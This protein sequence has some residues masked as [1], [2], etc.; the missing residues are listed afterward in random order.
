MISGNSSLPEVL[1]HEETNKYIGMLKS[2]DDKI[3]KSKLIEHNL[4][5]VAYIADR[6]KNT[7]IDKKD[8]ISIGTI[9]LIKAVNTFDKEKNFKLATYATRCIENEIL[10]AI[11]HQKNKNEVSLD[12]PISRDK[13][14][15]ELSFSD[16]ISSN[17][18]IIGDYE[19]KVFR[20]YFYELTRMSK[21]LND[22]E[23]KIVDLRFGLHNGIPMTQLQIANMM[24]IS[25][26]YISRIEKKALKL[27]RKGIINREKIESKSDDKKLVNVLPIKMTYTGLTSQGMKSAIADPFKDSEFEKVTEYIKE[28]SNAHGISFYQEI[29]ME[30]LSN[31]VGKLKI[32]SKEETLLKMAEE[33]KQ[34]AIAARLKKSEEKL[35]LKKA[36]EEAQLKMAEEKM[37]SA[38]AAKLKIEEEK[39]RISEEKRRISY[40][41]IKIAIEKRRIKKW[42]VKICEEMRIVKKQELCIKKE[43]EAQQK[44][45][46]REEKRI[47]KEQELCIKKEAEAQQ[48]QQAREEKRKVKEQELSI[49]KEEAAQQKQQSIEEKS[50]IKKEKISKKENKIF[51]YT[52]DKAQD[53]Y[54][55]LMSLCFKDRVEYLAKFVLEQRMSIDDIKKH[56]NITEKEV[57]NYLV[58]QLRKID[59]VTF[60]KV[61]KVWL[62][63]SIINS[64]I[65]TVTS[66]SEKIY[67]NTEVNIEL[68]PIKLSH[69]TDETNSINNIESEIQNEI[70]INDRDK[71]MEILNMMK[72]QIEKAVYC[73]RNGYFDGYC[74]S[75]E[76]IENSSIL[77]G[78]DFQYIIENSYLYIEKNIA[79]QAIFIEDSSNILVKE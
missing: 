49:K 48:K 2:S 6:F 74:Y 57:R 41:K 18:D 77:S 26:S 11:R 73:L 13:D 15:N 75:K 23:I 5:L 47:V 44:Q 35:Q 60:E 59:L 34:T 66:D 20:E 30:N 79:D 4:R 25:Q 62:N 21:T 14:G 63:L 7:G 36:K 33:K 17:C 54:N 32:M 1:S 69:A 29:G 45:Q 50:K 78:L 58:K 71:L 16:I 51:H 24:G 65:Q 3:A 67:E 52:N 55:L 12:E 46:E 8:L 38:R 43:E 61:R 39:K 70:I 42:Q 22:R 56:F 76:E 68:S 28:Y 72:M 9:G 53:N 19:K 27:L 64:N 31:C 40:E 10:M 37:I